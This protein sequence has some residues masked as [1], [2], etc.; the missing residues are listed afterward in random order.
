MDKIFEDVLIFEASLSFFMIILIHNIL[1]FLAVT[2][3]GKESLAVPAVLI[4]RMETVRGTEIEENPR[5]DSRKVRDVVEHLKVVAVEFFLVVLAPGRG[6]VIWAAL[7][8]KCFSPELGDYEGLT[9][10][11][12]PGCFGRVTLPGMVPAHIFVDCNDIEFLCEIIVHHEC[13]LIL[14]ISGKVESCDI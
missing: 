4:G 5:R 6:L 11:H 8:Q 3:V 1:G 7:P 14:V 2:L 9:L 10:R 13:L 12:F